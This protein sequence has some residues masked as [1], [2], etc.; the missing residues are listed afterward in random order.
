MK[1]SVLALGLLAALLASV[2]AGADE[3]PSFVAI[4]RPGMVMIDPASR[5]D[6]LLGEPVPV[7]EALCG[8]EP[9]DR[10]WPRHGPTVNVTA[11]EQPGETLAA[12][13]MLASAVHMS[14]ADE[15]D[16]HWARRAVIHNLRYWAKHDGLTR[17]KEP[18]DSNNFYNLDRTLLP[19][20]VGYAL[21]RDDPD[22][23]AGDIDDIDD[24]LA[25]ITTLRYLERQL[26]PTRVTSRNNHSYLRASVTM[27]WG[28]LTGH[29]TAYLEGVST[30]KRAL[31]QLD[32]E[33]GLPLEIARGER[34]LFYHRHA[35]ASLVAI[36]EMAAA[37]G[38]DLYAET[39]ERGQ[40]LHALVDFLAAGILDGT[41]QQD[42]SFLFERGH[43]R[44]YMAWF[45]AYRARFSSRPATLTI[46]GVL[47]RAGVFEPPVFDDYS[48]AVTSC[49]FREL[50]L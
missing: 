9:D 1:P 47:N 39:N 44:H 49:L 23:K 21:V 7:V 10:D 12:T 20:I 8:A 32:A 2:P 41:G 6:L 18:V 33:G 15:E 38:H 45:E 34:S 22:N 30:Y 4:A 40:S 29:E 5:R 13:I 42:L 50:P 35:L 43:D 26:D 24:W 36:A 25:R 16:R 28:A 14:A 19:I 11:D 27:A 31:G 17:I 37:Q 3:L 48:G 46:E